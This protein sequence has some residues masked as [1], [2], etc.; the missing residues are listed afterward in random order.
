MQFN[1]YV[2]FV[3]QG[4]WPGKVAHPSKLIEEAQEVVY[5]ADDLKKALEDLDLGTYDEAK[6]DLILELGDTLCSVILVAH[7]H[8]MTIQQI[9][10]ASV[11]KFTNRQKYG[12]GN[13]GKRS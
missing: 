13:Y 1:D 6:E 9:I 7:N 10:D 5:A 12:K 11:E 4:S 2:T 3:L 8:G